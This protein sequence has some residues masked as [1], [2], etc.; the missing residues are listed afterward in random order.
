[1]TIP[2]R[3]AF[4]CIATD[5]TRWNKLISLRKFLGTFAYI[6]AFQE[7]NYAVCYA[8][9]LSQYR[10][11]L[12]ANPSLTRDKTESFIRE[13]DDRETLLSIL[14]TRMTGQN[15]DVQIAPYHCLHTMGLLAIVGNHAIQEEALNCL[16]EYFTH[17]LKYIYNPKL[18]DSVDVGLVWVL[19]N[20]FGEIGNEKAVHSLVVGSYYEYWSKQSIMSQD[21]LANLVRYVNEML[22]YLQF[23]NRE[24]ANRVREILAG[25]GSEYDKTYLLPYL[26]IAMENES[27]STYVHLSIQAYLGMDIGDRARPF[28]K[29]P[30]L[31]LYLEKQS[32]SSGWGYYR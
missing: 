7:L 15:S 24:A 8:D 9:I 12:N 5:L 17:P 22:Y 6:L 30:A 3:L 16:I 11:F 28:F 21:R 20:A 26:H 19:V 2:L 25:T 32:C 10:E 14:K 1:M 29:H 27:S 18:T 31:V 4:E 23:S 13:I